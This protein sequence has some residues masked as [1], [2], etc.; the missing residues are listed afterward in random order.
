VLRI[1]ILSGEEV[2]RKFDPSNLCVNVEDGFV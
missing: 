1:L 2:M